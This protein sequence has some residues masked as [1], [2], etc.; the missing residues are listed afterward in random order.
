MDLLSILKTIDFFE[1]LTEIELEQIGALCTRLQLPRGDT[2]TQQGSYGDE[3]YIIAEG[4]VE[5]RVSS[6]SNE[7][8]RS[9]V[10]LGP[11]QLVGEMVLVDKGTRSA[12]T[13]SLS[14]PTVLYRIKHDEFE[15]LC[16]QNT[17]IG[18][19]VMRNIASDLSF[20]LRHQNLQTGI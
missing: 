19:K 17:N 3:L 12:T 14:E 1:G 18:Y 16:E 8:D 4:F 15:K 9:V 7:P 6:G 20:K 5:V 2:I 11:G 13:V 10:N